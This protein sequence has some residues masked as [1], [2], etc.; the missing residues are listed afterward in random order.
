MKSSNIF[1][2]NLSFVKKWVLRKVEY[3][4]R[5][6]TNRVPGK[7]W[8]KGH[9]KFQ[10]N[11][12]TQW[13][14]TDPR[15]LSFV[16]TLSSPTPFLPLDPRKRE[17]E[18]R[19]PSWNIQTT[20]RVSRRSYTVHDV[21]DPNLVRRERNIDRSDPPCDWRRRLGTQWCTRGYTVESRR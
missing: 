19:K 20:S 9:S 6:C 1:N 5:T 7:K 21:G 14:K 2:L 18:R 12:R 17:W 16:T 4:C 13:P 11:P 10:L 15:W 8:E 3:T